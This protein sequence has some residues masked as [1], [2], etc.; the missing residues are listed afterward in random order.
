MRGGI[1]R[2][3][4]C[5]FIH[6]GIAGSAGVDLGSGGDYRLVCC[7]VLDNGGPGLLIRGDGL[8]TIER[9]EVAGNN[10]AGVEVRTRGRPYLRCCRV[11]RNGFAGIWIHS[12]GAALLEGCELSDNPG[13]AME[14]EP[15]CHVHHR[16]GLPEPGKAAL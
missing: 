2:V 1:L 7:R 3:D 4:G 16:S 8:G 12:R 13:G 11:Q 15:G 14:V 10:R 9:C 6:N 5:D